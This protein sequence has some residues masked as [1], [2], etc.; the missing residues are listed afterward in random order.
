MPGPAPTPAPARRRRGQAAANQILIL[1]QSRGAHRSGRTTLPAFCKGRPSGSL[2][3]TCLL[4]RVLPAACALG[5]HWP[6]ET[7]Q[8]SPLA[9]VGGGKSL[10]ASPASAFTRGA[11][12][13]KQLGQGSLKAKRAGLRV[14]I[15]S[16]AACR[17]YNRRRPFGQAQ[18]GRSG[19]GGFSSGEAF[20]QRR[21]SLRHANL[22]AAP[23]N[24]TPA[25]GRGDAWEGGAGQ[26]LQRRAERGQLRR[27]L[28]FLPNPAAS[29]F[30]APSSPPPP[31]G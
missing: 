20:G 2:W 11:T 25:G 7:R 16:A 3:K 5:P 24:W 10:P 8:L 21:L 29:P 26:R 14:A 30:A 9:T 12:R 18:A 22:S 23:N 28:A 19:G 4:C 31:A 27:S 13:R 6:R 15:R 1:P 17:L